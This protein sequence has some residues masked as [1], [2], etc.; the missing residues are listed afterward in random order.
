MLQAGVT[1]LFG[2]KPAGRT[3]AVLCKLGGFAPSSW[4]GKAVALQE[5]DLE[6]VMCCR[7]FTVS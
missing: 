7:Y 2:G 6:Q 4:L 1:L 5:C 3:T